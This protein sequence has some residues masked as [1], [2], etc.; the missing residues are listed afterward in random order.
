MK[1]VSQLADEAVLIELGQRLARTRLERNLT[2]AE[3][4][5]EAGVGLAT[6]QRLER[7]SPANLTSVIRILR[8]LKLLDALEQLVPEPVP[9]PLE[10]LKLQGKQ[11]RRAAH[12]R[13]VGESR[14]DAKPWTWGDELEGA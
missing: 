12:T 8:V 11:R 2:Q 4:A 7:G 1:I 5:L 3:L 6:V 14:P 9:S 10:F 13:A